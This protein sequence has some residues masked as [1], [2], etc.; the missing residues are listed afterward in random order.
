[1]KNKML[2]SIGV[3]S[4]LLGSLFV[5]G[6]PSEARTAPGCWEGQVGIYNQ[7]DYKGHCYGF[8]SNNDHFDQY[9]GIKDQMWSA[10]NGGTEGANVC[11][12]RSKNGEGGGQRINF[13]REISFGSVQ[14]AE[15]NRW[16]C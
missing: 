10:W 8:A 9:P 3:I 12:Y 7:P 2:K 13:G 6:S 11:I 1:M 14:G 5:A 16:H 4:V 15:S